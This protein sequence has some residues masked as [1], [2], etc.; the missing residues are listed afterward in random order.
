MTEKYSADEVLEMAGEIETRGAKFYRQAARFHAAARDILTQIAG[1]EDLHFKTFAG[2][3]RALAPS[4]KAA[5]SVDPYGEAGM[6]LS[7]IVDAYGFNVSKDPAGAIT[8]KESLK[9]VFDMAI[10]MERDSII[11]YLGLQGLVPPGMGK[12][13]IDGIIKEEMKHIAWL[14]DKRAELG[15]AAS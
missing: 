14:N 2:M 6:Y 13:R 3:R 15:V 11:F 1:Q 8:G 7:A 9:D 10:N 12:D 5:E 4:E